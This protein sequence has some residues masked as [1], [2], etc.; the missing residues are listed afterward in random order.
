MAVGAPYICRVMNPPPNRPPYPNQG[1][2]LLI[3]GADRTL[4]DVALLSRMRDGDEQAL[5]TFYDR[6]H[7][8]VHAVAQR[9]I[10]NSDDVDD[11][12]EDTFWQA[13]RQ[14]RRYEAGRGSVQTWLLTIARSRALDRVRAAKRL[15]EEPI[16]TDAGERAVQ[17]AADSDP[18]MDAES[19]ERR[20]IVL[21]ALAELP[22]EQRQALE[23]GYYAG[24][25]QSEIAERTSQPLGTVKTRMRLAMQKLKDGLRVL[26]EDVR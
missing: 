14:A 13:W 10:R 17:V 24:L 16:E 15:R 5:G 26:H 2:V 12:V 18:A 20:R 23:L 3:P 1:K 21:A 6:W 9:I 11:V 22:A 8:L 19:S 25:S 7:A 4:D